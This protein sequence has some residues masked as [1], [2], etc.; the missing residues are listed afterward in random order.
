MAGPRSTHIRRSTYGIRYVMIKEFARPIRLAAENY[1]GRRAYFVTICSDGRSPVFRDVERAEWIVEALLRSATQHEFA[2]PA[3]C[4][5]PDH[6]HAVAQAAEG[7]CNLTK[8]VSAFK[9]RTAFDYSK[10]CASRLWQPRYYEHIL[11]QAEDLESVALYVWNNPVRAGICEMAMEYPFSGST[12]IDWRS[13]YKYLG[14][15]VPPWK[16]RKEEQG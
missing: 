13:R 12:T 7:A 6:L 4:V 5:M 9:Q 16:S 14:K 11:R 1:V 2:L 8:F 10:Q 3:Y 15:W